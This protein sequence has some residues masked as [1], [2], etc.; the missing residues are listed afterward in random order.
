MFNRLSL[1]FFAGLFATF[2]TAAFALPMAAPMT[3]GHTLTKVY[4]RCDPQRCIDPRTGEYS[5]STC[6]ASGCRPL[7]GIVGQTDPRGGYS[8]GGY[9]PA[10]YQGGYHG[11]GGF[12]CN[13]SRCIELSTGAVWESHC[14][15]NGC[16]PLR[17]ARRN[18]RRY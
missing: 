16:T 9:G 3:A 13:P 12:D 10:P 8:G 4:M 15:Y 7:G 1:I 17:P 6:D 18:Y 2:S 11:G 14:D 5:Q